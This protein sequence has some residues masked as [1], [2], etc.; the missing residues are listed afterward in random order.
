MKASNSHAV[1]EE[2]LRFAGTMNSKTKGMIQPTMATM[3]V[4]V[5]QFIIMWKSPLFPLHPYSSCLVN[6]SGR[7]GRRCVCNVIQQVPLVWKSLYAGAT[8]RDRRA[9]HTPHFC[10]RKPPTA[11]S[12]PFSQGNERGFD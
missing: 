6:A 11:Q 12:T 4:M 10:L 8:S 3:V 9:K 5:V 7:E 1:A 2:G